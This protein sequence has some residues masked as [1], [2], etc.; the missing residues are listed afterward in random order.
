V[1]PKNSCSCK[2][3]VSASQLAASL[4]ALAKIRL[5]DTHPAEVTSPSCNVFIICAPL[6]LSINNGE[7]PLS[8]ASYDTQRV[9]VSGRDVPVVH[10]PY[11]SA[12]LPNLFLSDKV[13]LIM[14][15]EFQISV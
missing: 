7:K 8:I 3:F 14:K 1:A 15:V 11:N 12:I 5:A 6:R 4:I 2:N 9:A 10:S 13:G